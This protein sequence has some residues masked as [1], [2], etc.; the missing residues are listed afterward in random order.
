[1]QKYRHSLTPYGCAILHFSLRHGAPQSAERQTSEKRTTNQCTVP[2][3]LR[4]RDQVSIVGNTT[5]GCKLLQK[6]T[7]YSG[8]VGLRSIH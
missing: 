4:F 3:C 6:Q 2:V 5:A 7:S 8:H 1:M